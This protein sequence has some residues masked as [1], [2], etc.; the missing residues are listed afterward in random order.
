MSRNVLAPRSAVLCAIN[1]YFSFV[2]PV[3]K[4]GEDC[5]QMSAG[6]DEVK[7]SSS[8]ASRAQAADVG[9]LTSSRSVTPHTRRLG[10]IFVYMLLVAHQTHLPTPLADQLCNP[11]TASRFG[12]FAALKPRADLTRHS[13][14]Q[15]L[16]TKLGRRRCRGLEHSHR[17]LGKPLNCRQSMH[18]QDSGQHIDVAHYWLC[19]GLVG[20]SDGKPGHD[21]QVVVTREAG[22]SGKLIKALQS[23]GLSVLELPLVESSPGP[24]R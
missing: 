11:V 4:E 23:R 15:S 13:K 5:R 12:N 16:S 18:S 8:R 20:S 19:S 6:F 24:D 2:Y 21:P 10:N 3:P 14:T 22:K 9:G 17:R 1:C 7:P